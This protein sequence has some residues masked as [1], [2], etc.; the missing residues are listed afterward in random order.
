MSKTVGSDAGYDWMGGRARRG[1]VSRLLGGLC[2]VIVAL[3]AVAASA[4]QIIPT[5]DANEVPVGGVAAV[6]GTGV[7]GTPGRYFVASCTVAGAVTVT[8]PDTTTLVLPLVVGLNT[9]KY[10]VTKF[11]SSTATCSYYDNLK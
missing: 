10:S 6:L 11:A 8:F 4:Q 7:A 2:G 1:L 9:F 3:S 5:R